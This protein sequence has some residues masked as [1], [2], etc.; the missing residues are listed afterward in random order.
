MARK[1][2]DECE[3]P[4]KKNR[5][6]GEL[7]SGNVRRL[8]YNGMK[9]KKDKQ[10]NPMYDADGKPIMIRD[11][12][13]V[14]ASN[15]TEASDL[16]AEAR[17]QKKN[18]KRPADMTLTEAIDK[19]ISSSD[20]ILSPTTISG[21]QTI[22]ENAFKDIINMELKKLTND[23]L[24]T[25][26]NNEAK[27]KT[28]RGTLIAPKTVI[29]EYG[30]LTAVLNMYAPALDT[31]VTL[32]SVPNNQ[33]ELSTPDVI[34]PLV[35]G[36]EIELAVLLAM[37]LSFTMSEIRGLKKSLSISSDG[38]YISIKKVVVVVDGKDV[39]KDV[40]KEETRHRTHRLPEYIKQLINKVEGDV[41][42]P[43]SAA[44]ISS[45]WKRIVK[46]AGIPHMTFHDL[47]H[48]NASVM[49]LIH[50]PDKYAQARGGWKT[51][52]VMKSNYMQ[53]FSVERV[54]VDDQID[55]WFNKT[56]FPSDD[57]IEIQK[58]KNCLCNYSTEE[59]LES[60]IK[61]SGTDALAHLRKMQHDL[62]HK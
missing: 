14:T 39:E 29:N 47:R 11:Y 33:N 44:K 22:Q 35:R 13:S 3:T 57:E 55:T 8:V 32:P 45:Q 36:T 42:V 26:L 25:A 61:I 53:T 18:K 2:A 40:A 46:K 34:F 30:L 17:L 7:P 59:I 62:Q 28:K 1:K 49:A 54:A 6:K 20:A 19:Y 16:V 31:Q 12:I 21:Y 41:I 37:W 48:V 56:L 9:Q 5:R 60:I 10:G 38:N 27:R 43:Y 51:D 50:I 58:L 23:I 4:K 52:A 24:R 15:S